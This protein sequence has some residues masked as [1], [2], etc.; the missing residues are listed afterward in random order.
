MK[1][2][3]RGIGIDSPFEKQA[4]VDISGFRLTKLDRLDRGFQG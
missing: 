2:L 1:W 4:M 3:T